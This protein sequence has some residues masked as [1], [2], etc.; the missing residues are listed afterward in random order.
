[1]GPTAAVTNVALMCAASSIYALAVAFDTRRGLVRGIVRHE[2]AAL[3]KAG[4]AV[5][6]IIVP[7]LAGA[8]TPIAGFRVVV[9]TWGK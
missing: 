3:A 1:M 7:I 4:A 6:L 8:L 9:S 5:L 2:D